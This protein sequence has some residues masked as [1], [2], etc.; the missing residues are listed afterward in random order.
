MKTEKERNKVYLGFDVSEKSI[1]V[2]G[3]C[4]DKTTEKAIRIANS[5]VGIQEFLNP[6]KTKSEMV[7]IAME[8]GTHSA[9]M[10]R[11]IRGLG[12]EESW[13]TQEI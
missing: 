3:V 9:W 4:G 6:L 5:R 12:F 7:C 1:E 11:Y 13:L 8:T 10:S 2:F